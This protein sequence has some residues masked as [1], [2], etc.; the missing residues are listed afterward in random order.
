LRWKIGLDSGL[1]IPLC[2][3]AGINTQNG[4]R[5][6]RNGMKGLEESLAQRG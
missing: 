3:F 4:M 1:C 5:N 2:A 6:F